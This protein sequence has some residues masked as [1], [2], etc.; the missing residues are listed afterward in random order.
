[1]I[2][3]F[4]STTNIFPLSQIGKDDPRNIE[5]QH[6]IAG[7]KI[8]D[9]IA[10]FGSPLFVFEESKIRKN[11][12]D[13]MRAFK[14]LYPNVVHGWSYKTN[15]LNAI[16]KIMHSEGSWA[17]VV[18]E[19]EYEKARKL[20]I[21]GSNIIYNG[22]HKSTTSLEKAITE[23]A[24]INIDNF[25][26]IEAIHQ[27]T[28]KV[29]KPAKVCIRI[30]C[31]TQFTERWVK[32]GF[33]YESGES[34]LAVKA[35][36][37]KQNINL[38]GIHNHIGTFVTEPKAYQ[39]SVK[40]MCN[41]A[42]EIFETTGQVM[43]IINIGGGFA[44]KNK[45]KSIYLPTELTTPTFEDY[46]NNICPYIIDFYKA[47]FPTHKLPMLILESGRAMVDDSC[48]IISTVVAR[49]G[50]ASEINGYILDAGMNLLFTSSWYDHPVR[51]T[52]EYS[53]NLVKSTL[54]GPLCM[55][56]DILR[57]NIMLPKMQ[58]G[59]A[60]LILSA[61][62]YNVTQW[63]Q[64]IEMRPNVVLINPLGNVDILRH[65]ESVDTMNLQENTPPHL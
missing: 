33:N 38:V 21:H 9:L 6:E 64:F 48:S 8:E 65:K 29:Q 61:G 35:V 11:I 26:E 25:D 60:I 54:F 34:M 52:K 22:P 41:L 17:E 57:S 62:A 56:I 30:N 27:L 14:N 16:C 55:N 3:K 13:M 36:A 28:L 32:F 39:N 1:M 59:D 23:G 46:A 47:N 5:M 63:M 44:S 42:K 12:Q 4:S 31:E 10:Q 18:S 19:F 45:L 49:K 2:D 53:G 50:V 51:T 40:V 43:E 58:C 24:I 15:Y 37:Q 20:G 7:H